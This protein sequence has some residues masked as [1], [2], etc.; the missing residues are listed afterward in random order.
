MMTN[1]II[2][3]NVEPVDFLN[4][5]IPDECPDEFCRELLELKAIEYG[6]V[7]VFFAPHPTRAPLWGWLRRLG[8]KQS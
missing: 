2:I 1:E 3:A 7:L 6:G 5:D 8:S 4:A